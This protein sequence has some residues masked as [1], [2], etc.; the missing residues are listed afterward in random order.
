MCLCGYM[1]VLSLFHTPP[2]SSI[3][4]EVLKGGWCNGESHWHDKKFKG[5]ITSLKQGFPL[6]TRGDANIVVSGA[7]VKLGVDFCRAQLVN[8]VGDQ[9]YRVSVLLGDLVKVPK[10]YTEPKGAIFL[11]SKKDWCAAWGA[12]CTNKTFSE[13]IIQEFL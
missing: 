9:W 3:V 12:R 8:E 1:F 7:Q 2:G 10:I 13:H 4:H 6:V 11:F 5:A